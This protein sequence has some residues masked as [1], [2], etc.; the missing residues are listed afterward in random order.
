VKAQILLAT[1]NPEPDLFTRQL[2][3]LTSQTQQD[4][5]CLVLDDASR[6]RRAV[7]D[8]LPDERFRL[9][10]ATQHLGPYRAFGTLLE[11]AG[12]V[13]VFPCD[14]D[15]HWHPDKLARLL[16]VPGTAFS[17][18]RVVDPSGA[19]V[20]QRFLPTP[21]DLSASS[22]LLMNCV[23]GTSM[24]VTDEVRRASLPLPAPQLRGWHDQ[25]LAAVAARLGSLTYVDEALVD[26]TQ[27]GAQVIGDGLRRFSVRRLRQFLSQP[28][29]RSRVDW[30]MSAAF[31]LLQL[32]GPED[33]DLQAIA[34]G[35]FHRLLRR[36]DI[37]PQRAILLTAGRW[38][39]DR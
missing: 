28:E 14:Q 4:W 5:Q 3:S 26:Y 31:R 11:A 34:A 20:R 15:D 25:W 30:V 13:P 29:F 24:K 2:A 35:D 6:D 9:L 38:L 36:Y 10:P 17:A 21:T 32:P 7:R 37:P 27:H 19:V 12:A 16:S 8:L 18:M 33:P 1:H 23:A 39:P 22:L